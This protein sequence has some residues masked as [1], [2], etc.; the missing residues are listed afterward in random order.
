MAANTTAVLPKDPSTA[1]VTQHD[2]DLTDDI[3]TD[4]TQS[5]DSEIL[6]ETPWRSVI[7]MGVIAMCT[8]FQYSTYLSSM[9]PNLKKLDPSIDEA[10]F[11]IAA[12][13]YP[14]GQIIFSPVFGWWS[15]HLKNVKIPLIT[16]MAVE[17]AGNVIYIF[18]QTAPSTSKYLF[19]VGR[20]VCGIGTSNV[21]LMKAYASTASTDND[22]AA[23]IATVMG[24]FAIGLIVGP[25]VQLGLTPIGE[26]GLAIFPHFAINMYTLPAVVSCMVNILAM[27]L[28]IFIFREE[29]GGLAKSEKESDEESKTLPD[30]DRIGFIVCFV[31]NFAQMFM[32][33]TI[34]TLSTP[35]A[36]TLFP[37]TRTEAVQ[38]VSVVHGIKSAFDLAMNGAFAIFNVGKWVNQRWACLVGFIGMGAFYVITFP[39]PFIPG[40]IATYK[41][42]EFTNSTLEP[43]G[44]DVES[45]TWC[46]Y[47]HPVNF[48]LYYI[49]FVIFIGWSFSLVSIAMFTVF[50]QLIG[51]RRQSTHHGF[52]QMIGSTGRMIGP[53]SISYMYK[54]QG[55]YEAWALDTAVMFGTALLWALAFKRLRPLMDK[56]K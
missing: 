30:F 56:I 20:F 18:L 12:S 23:A 22:R 27:V 48:W 47:T 31:A 50:S 19:G 13:C 25:L 45:L 11:G 39:Y 32:F 1:S 15:N 41:K 44:C 52:M 7:L 35:I 53:S 55:I 46:E 28:L 8:S 9:W 4:D 3:K 42:S 29:Y 37:L 34:E 43:I 49:S 54:N 17:C 38:V 10:F 16:A 26:E 40:N 33:G 51:P 2:T 21:G 14:L 6:H 36:M 5:S 24:F